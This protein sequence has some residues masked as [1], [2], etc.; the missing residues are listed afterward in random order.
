MQSQTAWATGLLS[1]ILIRYLEKQSQT[2][3]EPIPYPRILSAAPG[4]ET[5]RDPEAFLKDTNHWIPYTVLNELLRYGEEVTGQKDMA[6]Q[7]ALDFF[8][9]ANERIPSFLEMIAKFLSNM[10]WMLMSSNFWAEA[11]TNYLKLQCLEKPEAHNEVVILAQYDSGVTPLLGNHFLVQG[12]YEGFTRL[13]DFVKTS[14]CEVEFSQIKLEDLAAEFGGYRKRE[15]GEL[16]FLEE[17]RTGKT[18]AEAEAV[19]LP[20]EFLP[21]PRGILTGAM[22]QPL[23][24]IENGSVRVFTPCFF[25]STSRPRESCRVFRVRQG[26][27]LQSGQLSFKLEPGQVYDAPY[28]RYRFFWE[29]KE[30]RATPVMNQAQLQQISGLL[31]RHLKELKETQRRLLTFMVNNTEL[32]SE[33]LHLK[34]EIKQE[35]GFGGIIGKSPPMR[36][37]FTLIKTLAVTDSTV[38]IQG[39]TGT[40]KELVA[41][42]IH[43]TS[44]RHEGRFVAINC[45]ALSESLLESELF[46]HERGAFT[47]AV[48]QKKGKFELAHGGTIFLDEIGEVSSAMQVKLLRVLQEREVQRVGGNETITVDVRVV[49]ATNQNLD[50]RMAENRFRQDLYYRLCVVPIQLVALRERTEDVPLLVDH[51]VTKHQQRLKKQIAGFLPETVG[52]LLSYFWPGNIRELENVIERAILLTAP[53]SWITPDLLPKEL[54]AKPRASQPFTSL[55]PDG[56]QAL[57]NSVKQA[58]SMDPVLRSIE[59]GLMKR[60]IQEHGGN[61][62]KAAKALGR[63]YR[64]L[65]KLEKTNQL[66]SPLSSDR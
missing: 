54:R 34:E 47:G 21:A 49:A 6:Y 65:R 23:L 53:D 48:V 40:G 13:Y 52:C 22:D 8:S 60:M 5:V 27:M 1:H 55:G 24:P 28:S 4:F 9:S 26:G 17:I 19:W 63:T 42:L 11:Y 18:V 16:I 51:F 14:R 66:D 29:E 44:L 62:S 59:H 7:A 64:W 43:Y 50:Q 57:T 35:I 32:V 12:N 38:L 20:Y 15:S 46:G 33:N 31:F 37:L 30:T 10:Q 2:T 3:R 56:W 58:G 61:K 45:G 36:Q 41:R 25:R 39:E